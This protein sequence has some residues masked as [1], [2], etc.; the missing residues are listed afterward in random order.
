[1]KAVVLGASGYT[2]MVLLR[3][4]E[5]HPQITEITAV[6]STKAG[7][8]V[9]GYDKGL[10]SGNSLKTRENFASVDEIDPEKADVVFSCLPHLT[11]AEVCE[12]FIGKTTVI[13]LSADFRL[14]NPEDFKKSYG[15]E[16]PRPQYQKSAV[17]GLPEIYREKIKK[18]GLI[19]NP[20]CYPTAA[21][22]PLIPFISMTEGK[23]II[24]S[25]SGISGAGKKLNDN[26]LYCERVENA[27]A[28]LPGTE[29]R[30]TTEIQK[31]ISKAGGNG[32]PVFFT[33]HLVPAKRGMTSTIHLTLCSDISEEEAGKI[34]SEHYSD[35]PFIRIRGTEIPQMADTRGSNR[36][37]IG[38]RV[39]GRHLMLFS[40]IDNLLKGASGMA[41][42][43]M[44]I[45]FGFEETQGLP[46]NN[47]L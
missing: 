28:Y 43:N 39:F 27:G 21:L 32:R 14:E 8:T 16:P 2:G 17:Y 20:G 9:S 11:S 5:N 31:E 23:I 42:Q 44:N 12:T 37:D 47:Q 22:L 25:L 35:S 7:N 30:H 18:S 19:A 6:S 36:C 41:V 13:D 38:A 45:R 29:H 40:S 24:D 10:Y 33:P 4:L 1:M 3:L 15:S 34:L 26:L 46:V